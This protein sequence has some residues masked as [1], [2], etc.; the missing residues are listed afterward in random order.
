MPLFC[1]NERLTEH[2]AADATLV[3]TLAAGGAPNRFVALK[4]I[5]AIL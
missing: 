1:G 4:R 5:N 3:V 2:A